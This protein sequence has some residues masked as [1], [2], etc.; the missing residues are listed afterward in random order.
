MRA[1]RVRQ[2]HGLTHGLCNDNSVEWIGYESVGRP[3]QS[4]DVLCTDVRA[5]YS[6]RPSN[7]SRAI[8]AEIGMRGA[9]LRWS[10]C[11]IAISQRLATLTTIVFS[12][13][14]MSFACAMGQFGVPC[15]RPKRDVS[16]E[17]NSH[18]FPLRAFFSL[19][20]SGE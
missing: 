8:V 11:L 1:S 17:Q 13:S 15:D 14:S 2:P 12:I 16:I 9:P 5:V 6:P 19:F 10:A 20:F 4:E 7:R 18:R 3:L